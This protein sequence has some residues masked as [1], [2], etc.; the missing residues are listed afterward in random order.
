MKKKFYA[1]LSVTLAGLS[2]SL[3]I[4]CQATTP[5][6]LQAKPT[7][8]SNSGN[9]AN[10]TSGKNSTLPTTETGELPSTETGEL[11]DT[12]TGELPSTD[13][14]E[15]PSTDSGNSGNSSSGSNTTNTNNP[16]SNSGTLADL[17]FAVKVNGFGFAN[18]DTDKYD[19]ANPATAYLTLSSMQ[20]M[21][22]DD[23]VCTGTTS[24]SNCVPTP[25]AKKW[26]DQI[27]TGMN[28]GQCEGMAVFSLALFKGI[29]SI[30]P[31][32]AGKTKTFDL[33]YNSAV[34]EKIGYYFAY[35]YT[36]EVAKATIKGTPVEI[37]E[38]L[39]PYLSNQQKDPVT[40][41][42]YAPDGKGGHAT[43][44]YAIVDKGN[45]IQHILMYDNNWPGQERYIEVDTQANTWIYNFGATNPT[46]KADAWKGDA[47]S[48]TLEFTL[49]SARLSKATCPYCDQP[50]AVEEKSKQIFLN[51]GNSGNAHIKIVDK[52]DPSKFIGWD[53]KT[54]RWVNNLP[55][56]SFKYDK[57]VL[58]SGDRPSAPV[59]QVPTGK[60]FEI[61]VS[62]KDLKQAENVGVSIFGQGKSMK[63]DKIDLDPDQEDT[64]TLPADGDS[65][66]YKPGNS[67]DKES[68]VFSYGFDNPNGKDYEF[69]VQ[70]LDA[71][72]DEELGTD[73]VGGKLQVSDSGGGA[74]KYD[75]KVKRVNDD[76][77]EADY[78]K[79]DVE[80]GDGETDDIDF[81][82]WQ[83]EG[84]GMLIGPEGAMAEEPDVDTDALD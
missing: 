52:N 53:E 2:L 19:P 9:T 54:Q 28:G 80:L 45:G 29:E 82:D 40:L 33:S 26:Q 74:D 41:G 37:I 20:K 68:P 22:G 61:K 70:N 38:K 55:G 14:G 47:E 18:G 21:F 5:A 32:E 67:P 62:G 73:L 23:K 4:G 30:N 49:L 64:L 17:G 44:P 75:V 78:S 77:S 43:T 51:A 24:G 11:T 15:L 65:M 72:N 57:S 16:P 76:G 7:T 31:L 8:A 42:F 10:P 69:E 25:A 36:Q 35:Q 3:L 81:E 58:K 83:G 46:E 79:D 50:E 63:I 13:T 1:P 71:D 27:N 6:N 84:Q 39:K 56:A 48:K 66:K 34:K 60:A 59:I 12:E